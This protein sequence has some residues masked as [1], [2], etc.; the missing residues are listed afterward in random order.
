MKKT[1]GLFALAF[2]V[3]TACGPS[4]R[5]SEPEDVADQVMDILEDLDDMS[6]EDFKE[7]FLSLE[8]FKEMAEDKEIITDADLRKAIKKR[9]ESEYNEGIEKGFSRIIEKGSELKIKWD[10]IEFVDFEYEVEKRGGMKGCG[11]RVIFKS[12]GKKYSVR[13]MSIYD[14]S[15]YCL[16]QISSP[17]KY[18]D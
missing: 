9:K 12:G 17:R 8:E 10:E 5:V 6:K 1:I 11:G 14:G 18:R 2:I 16:M 4:S 13:S 15:G 3:L 7:H